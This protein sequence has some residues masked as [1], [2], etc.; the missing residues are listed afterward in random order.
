M[1]PRRF[2]TSSQTRPGSPGGPSLRPIH[3]TFLRPVLLAFLLPCWPLLPSP[4]F[5]I[6]SLSLIHRPSP[7]HSLP[8]LLMPVSFADPPAR[9]PARR[10]CWYHRHR[11]RGLSPLNP[12]SCGHKPG[13]LCKGHGKQVNAFHSAVQF[14]PIDAWRRRHS[15]ARWLTTTALCDDL[16]RSDQISRQDIQHIGVVDC[17]LGYEGRPHS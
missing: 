16:I 6:S 10:C 4:P 11:R 12:S 13:P 17:S 2:S 5:L 9:Q 15:S 14:C 8:V 1:S 7:N 3:L